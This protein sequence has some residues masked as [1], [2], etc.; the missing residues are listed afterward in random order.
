MANGQR[1][2]RKK[3]VLGKAIGRIQ[4]VRFHLRRDREK[5]ISYERTSEIRL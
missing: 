1:P 4:K 3:R 2:A 5:I